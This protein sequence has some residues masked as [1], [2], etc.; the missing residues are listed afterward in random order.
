VFFAIA[1]GVMSWVCAALDGILPIVACHVG[2]ADLMD[3]KIKIAAS[4]VNAL[5]WV[6]TSYA[7]V[8]YA[9]HLTTSSNGVTL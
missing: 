9:A 6:K 8:P 4:A 1:G 5:V 7:A 2:F 3:Y